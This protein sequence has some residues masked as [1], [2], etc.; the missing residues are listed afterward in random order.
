MNEVLNAQVVVDTYWLNLVLS[1]VI[2]GL[3]ALVTKRVAPS[4]VKSVMLIL[5]V[6][7]ASVIQTIVQAG[8]EFDV[9][10]TLLNFVIT[11]VMAVAAHFGFLK[12]TMVT[13]SEGVIQKAVPGGVGPG[14]G[15]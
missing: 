11:F 3:V 14:T 2:P 1:V 13:G 6:A 5:L 7:I 12:P 15:I 9:K 8:G 10:T 4:W